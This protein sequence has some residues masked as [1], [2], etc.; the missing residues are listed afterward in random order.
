MRVGLI[1]LSFALREGWE[2]NPC[3][4]RLANATARVALTL[5]AEGIQYLCSSQ[6]EIALALHHVPIIHVVR[7]HRVKGQ[8]LDSE[9]VCAQSLEAF[10]RAGGVDSILPIAQPFLQLHKVQQQLKN[11]GQKLF[12][13]VRS[14]QLIGWI[15]F[16][17]D[18]DQPWTRSAPA[19]LKYALE[20]MKK[21]KLT[22]KV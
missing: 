19:L 22:E 9:E 7:E 21:G 16:D 5:N 4:L 8:Y 6:W 3:N 11:T 2:P 1:P 15:G 10:D 17:K 20:Q 18:S 12:W 14:Y 13:P